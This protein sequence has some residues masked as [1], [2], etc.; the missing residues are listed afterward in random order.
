MRESW[1]I[2]IDCDPPV[3]MVATVN[4]RIIP[5]D[6]IE[7]EANALYLAG[8]NLVQVPDLAAMLND[9]ADR[10]E[11]GI[12]GVSVEAMAL[13]REEADSV[14]GSAFNIG[15]IEFD[16]AWQLTKVVWLRQYRVDKINVGHQKTQVGQAPSRSITLSLGTGNTGRSSAPNAFFTA[17][18][19]ARRST[20]DTILDGVATMTV[21]ASRRFGIKS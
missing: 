8:A 16:D 21:Q 6:A 18:D 3:R 12:S 17:A 20:D 5:A 19:Q 10:I 2:R 7:S 14:K 15:R 11:I 1:L 9:V 4:N 13:A